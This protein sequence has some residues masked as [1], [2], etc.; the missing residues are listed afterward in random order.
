MPETPEIELQ[1]NVLC[2]GE[3]LELTSTGFEGDDVTYHWYFN[4]GNTN[5]EISQTTI[6]SL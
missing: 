3:N 1:E 5:T 2:V 6:P 4:D